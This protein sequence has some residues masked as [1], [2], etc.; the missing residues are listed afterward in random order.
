MDR[1]RPR[2]LVSESIGAGVACHLAKRHPTEVAGLVLFA[3]FHDLP[4]VAQRRMPL[5]PAYFLLLDRFNPAE[6]LREYHGPVK[7]V[8]AGADEIIP[9]NSG[10]R[11][12][13]EYHGPKELQVFPRAHHN[14][15]EEQADEWWKE[16][17]S[18]WQQNAAKRQ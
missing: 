17:F 1:T 5:L 12:F 14:E 18:F 7:F 10:R 4:S 16:T 8:V 2:Y 11:L 9:S 15:I 6:C 3:P 13:D